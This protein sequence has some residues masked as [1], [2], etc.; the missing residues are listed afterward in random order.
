MAERKW[1]ERPRAQWGIKRKMISIKTT[2]PFWLGLREYAK[3]EQTTQSNI[4]TTLARKDKQLHA[5]I[6][7]YEATMPNRRKPLGQAPSDSAQQA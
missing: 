6:S 5:L 7:R 4:L 2:V 1:P 3:Q